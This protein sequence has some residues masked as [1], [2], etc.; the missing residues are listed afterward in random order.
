MMSDDDAL[1]AL[2]AFIAGFKPDPKDTRGQISKGGTLLYRDLFPTGSNRFREND[3]RVGSLSID[4]APLGDLDSEDSGKSITYI[5]SEDSHPDSEGSP[6][7][8]CSGCDQPFAPGEEVLDL[9]DGARVHLSAGYACLIRY[10]ERWRRTVPPD[11][12][13]PAAGSGSPRRAEAV[14]SSPRNSI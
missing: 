9:A 11:A 3:S 1:P 10:G 14:K 5:N 12:P 4:L 6:P 13:R 7:R 8:I 2:R